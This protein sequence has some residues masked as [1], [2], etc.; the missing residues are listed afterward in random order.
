MYIKL[1]YF[2]FSAFDLEATEILKYME[3]N[4][5]RGKGKINKF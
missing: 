2:Y 3:R 4:M 5:V 1:D